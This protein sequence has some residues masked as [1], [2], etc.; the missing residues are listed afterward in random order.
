[1]TQ[2]ARC[3]QRWQPLNEIGGTRR[4]DPTRLAEAGPCKRTSRWGIDRSETGDTPC[5]PVMPDIA[6]LFGTPAAETILASGHVR[7]H[8]TGRTYGRKR[9]DPKKLPAH[10]ARKGPS[11]YGLLRRCAPR[12]DILFYVRS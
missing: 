4:G 2:T 12:N 7:P 3:R 1:M 10:L 8:P 11:T 6:A 9:S 5:N